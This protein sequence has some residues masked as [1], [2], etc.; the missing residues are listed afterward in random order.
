MPLEVGNDASQRALG[1][2][3]TRAYLGVNFPHSGATEKRTHCLVK[4][5]AAT[6]PR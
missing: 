2:V 4:K 5:I 3:A 6:R 1:L